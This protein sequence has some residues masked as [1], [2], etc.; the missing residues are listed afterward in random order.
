MIGDRQP[1]ADAKRPTRAQRE[2]YL[3]RLN[4]IEQYLVKKADAKTLEGRFALMNE[5]FSWGYHLG[6][7]DYQDEE[8]IE[9]VRRRWVKLKLLYESKN[10]TKE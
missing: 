7:R 6:M 8:E 10:S 1:K 9:Q 2:L 5:L 4:R 3:A